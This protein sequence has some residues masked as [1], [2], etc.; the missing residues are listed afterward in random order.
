MEG[1]DFSKTFPDHLNP[2]L[3]VLGCIFKHICLKLRLIRAMMSH[4]LFIYNTEWGG[5]SRP[6]MCI[7]GEGKTS[8]LHDIYIIEIYIKVVVFFFFPNPSIYK[9]Y[10]DHQYLIFCGCHLITRSWY[11]RQLCFLRLHHFN[12]TKSIW[13]PGEELAWPETS[14]FSVNRRARAGSSCQTISEF[15]RRN[16]FFLLV[17][18]T[19][20]KPFNFAWISPRQVSI[21]VDDQV[22]YDLQEKIY[23]ISSCLF[24][25]SRCLLKKSSH[26]GK[27][28]LLLEND[29]DVYL[30]FFHL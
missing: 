7:I 13:R 9:C 23:L 24:L 1:K 22:S 12:K 19:S 3:P 21:L 10:S 20:G 27:R 15:R 2:K 8:F 6:Q 11:L 18:C 28:E 25:V 5:Q 14:A 26:M 29:C 30:I 17:F 4:K 16:A